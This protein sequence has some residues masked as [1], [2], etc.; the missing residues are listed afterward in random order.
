MLNKRKNRS[1]KWR[2]T[3]K[4][5]E[6]ILIEGQQLLYNNK[7]VLMRAYEVSISLSAPCEAARWASFFVVVSRFSAANLCF[8]SG[9]YTRMSGDYLPNSL[10][11]VYRD[12]F[13]FFFILSFL[14]HFDSMIRVSRKCLSIQVFLSLYSA[15]P[16]YCT[17][18]PLPCL[19]P[20]S[21]TTIP[22]IAHSFIRRYNSNKKKKLT[23]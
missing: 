8:V 15:L 5:F 18:P 3:H 14:Y 19:L 6:K 23:L 10:L 1:I 9:V 22:S 21:I 2:C 17:P 16:S 7:R 4:R 20:Q 12:I 11:R 13:C